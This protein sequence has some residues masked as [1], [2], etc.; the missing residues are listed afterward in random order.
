[1]VETV[2][3]GQ[4]E[5]AVNA[6]VDAFLLLM[7]PN[8]GD[9]LQ[10]IK[11]GIMEMADLVVI[12]KADG[13]FLPKARAAKA[14]FSQALRLFPPG[15]SGWRPPV[16]LCSSLEEEGIDDLWDQLLKYQ[17]IQQEGSWWEKQR[18]DQALQWMEDTLRYR[19][20]D[21]FFEDPKVAEALPGLKEEVRQHKRS[22]IEAAEELIRRWRE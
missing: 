1:M 2:G 6:M 5:V 16:L 7:L 12:N 20:L 13:P 4:S 14:V 15:P 11:K 3:V 22:P 8:A 19:L 10:G 18:E 21:A 9:E 17:E